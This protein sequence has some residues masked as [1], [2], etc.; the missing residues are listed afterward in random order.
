MRFATV[1][2]E[3]IIKA[4]LLPSF[5]CLSF[6]ETY[7][8]KGKNSVDLFKSLIGHTIASVYQYENERSFRLDFEGQGLLFKMHGAHANLLRLENGKVVELFRNGL[9]ADQDLVPSKLDRPFNWSYANF[10]ANYSSIRN[11]FSPL[12]K[13]AWQFMD[14]QGFKDKTPE[15][16]WTMISDLLDEF[17]SGKFYLVDNGGLPELLLF[18]SGKVISLYQEPVSALNDFFLTRV[19]AETLQMEK[20][21]T[22]KVVREKIKG[23]DASIRQ[24]QR[25]LK[26]QESDQHYRVWADLLMAHLSDVPPGASAFS[27]PSFEDPTI[28][29]NIPVKAGGSPQK[30]AE[31]YYRKARNASIERSHLQQRVDQK[32]KEREQLL[33]MQQEIEITGELSIIRKLGHQVNGERQT[34]RAET[35]ALPYREVEFEGF[36][37]WIGKNA[38]AN[39]ELT[40]KHAGKN[41][42]W[43][44]AR[45][46][47]GSHVVIKHQSGKPFSK[48]LVEYA[49]S[50]AAY[51]SRRRTETLA[52]V[53]VTEKK[54]VRKKK[55]SPPGAVVMDRETV[56]MVKPSAVAGP[57]E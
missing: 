18:K 27:V 42:L 24:A 7:K 17:R 51:Y 10:I 55:G 53:S 2:D 11:F 49:A 3:L 25:Q 13:P 52:P 6:P 29:V 22:L 38:S 48:K 45:D 30:M 9:T 16:Q 5:A 40:L 43:L 23:A 15:E 8:R 35:V 36:R 50:L 12:G 19:K 4:S 32:E 54:Y 57:S 47:P 14:Q 41:D 26:H 56:W 46:V 28:T 31:V 34:K 33:A 21:R 44:H 37:I 1:K 20:S 39:D